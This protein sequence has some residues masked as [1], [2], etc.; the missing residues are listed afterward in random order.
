VNDAANI[1]T[2]SYSLTPRPECEYCDQK[3]QS[4]RPAVCENY[5]SAVCEDHTIN[6]VRT[7]PSTL[8]EQHHQQTVKTILD[9]KTTV[10]GCQTHSC[11]LLELL[12]LTYRTTVA[13]CHTHSCWLIELLLFSVK[14]TLA[15]CQNYSAGCQTH[16][17]WLSE[18]L[19]WVSNPL[20]LAVR[21]T[22]LGVKP[23]L[24]DC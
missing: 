10:T 17:C 2:K 8:S 1:V 3:L 5:T 9:Y 11:W 20:L 4:F 16:S 12:L 13:G 19:C 18:L 24:A 23:T 15:G 14:P 7:T 6:T 22:L 21:I